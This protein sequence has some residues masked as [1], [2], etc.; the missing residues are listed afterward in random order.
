MKF[1][2]KQTEINEALANVTR[3]VPQKSPISALEGVKIHL[4]KGSLE[5]TGY[6]LEL[7][8]QT[9]IEVQS[10]DVGECI[11]NSRLSAK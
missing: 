1:I 6:D 7:G 8:I 2:C 9:K 3:A 10:D 4:E 11:L 5:L